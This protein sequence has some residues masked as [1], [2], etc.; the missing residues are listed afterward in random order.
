MKVLPCLCWRTTRKAGQQKIGG[1]QTAVAYDETTNQKKKR[2]TT[3]GKFTSGAWGSK[4]LG[5]WSKEAHMIQLAI[6]K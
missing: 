5:G 3:W 4:R 1:I 2:K 6:Y